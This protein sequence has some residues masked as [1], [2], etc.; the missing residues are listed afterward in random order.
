MTAYCLQCQTQQSSAVAELLEAM[1][2]GRAFT[3]RILQRQRKQGETKEIYRDLLPGYVFLFRE[4]PL[5]SFYRYLAMNGVIRFLQ[6][7]D[8]SRELR[9][10]DYDFAARLYQREGK[11]GVVTALK[12]GDTVRMADPLFAAHDGRILRLD[13][14]KGRAKVAF[15]FDEQEIEVWVAC[16][17]MRSQEDRL[18][19]V[20]FRFDY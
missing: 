6:Y 3:P 2:T 1:G 17:V 15:T 5:E 20:F 4:E 18:S 19:E 13:I 10:A 9:G 12:E 7:E 14:R 16:D 11:V 8:K